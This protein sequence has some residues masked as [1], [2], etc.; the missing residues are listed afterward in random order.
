MISLAK[1]LF[2]DYILSGLSTKVLEEMDKLNAEF[3]QEKWT[4]ITTADDAIKKKLDFKNNSNLALADVFEIEGADHYIIK[5]YGG[6]N[7][8][9]EWK[10]YLDDIKT[11]ISK[12]KD[13]WVIRLDV[14]CP[15]DVWNLYIGIDKKDL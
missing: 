13:S 1:Y 12:F 10:K 2:R 15:D 3:P 9:G 4:R 5:I 8:N 6:L 14:D 7:G 11:V